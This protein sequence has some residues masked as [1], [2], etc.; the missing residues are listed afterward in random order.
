MFR[1]TN[2]EEINAKYGRNIGTNMLINVVNLVKTNISSEYLFVRYMGPKF[3]IVFSGADVDDVEEFI[4]DVKNKLESL[5]M[6]LKPTNKSKTKNKTIYISPKSNFVVASYYKGT[7]IEEVT[8]KLEEYL[9]N[10]AAD[11]STITGI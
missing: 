11:E 3:A 6:E 8:K 1:I 2:I 7:G 5:T 4:A 9:D 10:A